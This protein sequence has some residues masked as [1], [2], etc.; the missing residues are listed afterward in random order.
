MISVFTNSIDYDSY[1]NAKEH[2][3]TNILEIL[4]NENVKLAYPTQTIYVKK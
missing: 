1:L 3:N 4:E 2:I